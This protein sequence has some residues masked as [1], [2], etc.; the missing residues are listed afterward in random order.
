MVHW[1][2]C[3][4]NGELMMIFAICFRLRSSLSILAFVALWLTTSVQAQVTCNASNTGRLYFSTG[5]GQLQL[6]DGTGWYS[7][8]ATASGAVGIGTTSTPKGGVGVA[9]LAIDGTDSST[10][11]PHIQMTT[12][13]D[14][15]PLLQVLPYSHNNISINFDAYWD[16]VWRSSYA[17]SSFTIYK[18]L[19]HLLFG[20][21]SSTAQGSALNG[22]TAG[23]KWA[24][25]LDNAG[26]VGIGTTAPSAI[27]N[28]YTSANAVP[29]TTGTSQVGANIRMQNSGGASLDIGTMANGN[30]WLQSTRWNDLS[31][32]YGLLLNPN[33]GNVGIGTVS[34]ST[35]L[36]V[37]GTDPS[38]TIEN[39][40]DYAAG[41]GSSLVLGHLQASS[42]L[43]VAKIRSYLT[44]G[45]G[46]G[47]R[48]G[49]LI[50]STSTAGALNDRMTILAN[51]NV[52][53]NTSGPNTTLE[54]NGEVTASLG[55]YGQF[56]SIYGGYGAFWRNDGSNFYLLMTSASDAYGAWNGLRPFYVNITSGAV[57]MSNGVTVSSCTGCSVVAEMMPVDSAVD[58]GTAVC[59]DSESGKLSACSAD[60]SLTAIGIATLHAEQ[61]LRMGC[62]ASSSQENH[63]DFGYKAEKYW[64]AS[65]ACAGWFPVALSGV[66]EFVKAECQRP[67]GS[68]LKY[69]DRLV[70]SG[71]RA[72]FVRPLAPDEQGG[73]AILGKAM[74]ICRGDQATD[75]IQVHIK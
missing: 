36:Q 74:T 64:K 16:G 55:T 28:T 3:R 40:G 57:T 66:H 26:N 5:T 45:G 61:I 21:A 2:V 48:S 29:A 71:T 73:D 32:N 35:A 7:I 31:Q 38:L 43:P 24:M 6:C 53:I 27:L 20:Y 22:A 56:R 11:G 41:S 23:W 10:A 19:D 4:L 60:K 62:A 44:N 17:N 1:Q 42:N 30:Q 46:A 39:N 25:A 50:F 63:I 70:T 65:K 51:G 13:A 8:G 14:N 68:H 33:G 47:Q 49:N 52:G 18:I 58:E 69:G 37:E 67:D 34:P 12:S 9:K 59:I 15:Y 54:V 72:G 75:V